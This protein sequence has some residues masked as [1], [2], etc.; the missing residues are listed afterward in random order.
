MLYLYNILL[1]CGYSV[2]YFILITYVYIVCIL[3]IIYPNIIDR[4]YYDVMMYIKNELIQ[5]L[6][7]DI[8]YLTLPNLYNIKIS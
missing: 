2:M 1:M 3:C 8:K 4:V 6:I 5:K 7:Y